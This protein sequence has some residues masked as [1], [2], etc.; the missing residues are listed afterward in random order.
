MRASGRLVR[1]ALDRCRAICRP[2]VT[3]AQIDAEAVKVL[4]E[5]PGAVPLF[6]GYPA[7]G[8][9]T[10]AFPAVT[11]IS[12]NEEVVHG[13]PGPRV[14]EEGDLVSV[15]F[16]VRLNGW[17]GDSATTI[18]VGQVPT[19]WRELCEVTE[20][21]LEIAIE[22]I[23]PGVRWSAVARQMQTYAE[24]AGM[25]VVKDFVGH[26][27]GRQLHEE[28]KVPNFVGPELLR[29]DIELT[30]GM[31]LAVEPMCCLGT[32]RVR[33]LN[34]GWTVVTADGKPAAHY[35]HSIAVT[36]NGCE[37]LTDGR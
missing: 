37:V 29:N 35:E 19:R 2:G 7:P 4:A 5:N 18:L 33:L 1:E 24:E 16:G 8:P 17:C 12:V 11:C 28:P 34:D 31:V 26:G 15:D 9:S 27:I 3:T 25:G 36:S 10:P 23:R 21:V 30:P 13:I 20:H 14:I 6:K 32:E 22:N